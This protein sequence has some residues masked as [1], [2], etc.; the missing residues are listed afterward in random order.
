MLDIPVFHNIT[1]IGI[2]TLKGKFL[3]AVDFGSLFIR[4]GVSY[5]RT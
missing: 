5:R 2:L 4:R 1:D 3:P